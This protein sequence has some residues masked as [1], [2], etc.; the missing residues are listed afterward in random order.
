MPVSR[1]KVQSD[2][3]NRA[4][5][6]RGREQGRRTVWTPGR[7]YLTRRAPSKKEDHWHVRRDAQKR[8]G[9]SRESIYFSFFYIDNVCPLSCQTID[10]KTNL[11]Y[12]RK[13]T[14]IFAQE[15]DL[16]PHYLAFIMKSIESG[17]SL[18]S[19]PIKMYEH[20]FSKGNEDAPL[21]AVGPTAAIST[22]VSR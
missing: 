12:V 2:S 3:G 9:Q 21:V 6:G 10:I 4:K 11:R 1:G 16:D 7:H 18:K 19:D 13:Y 14:V 15:T 8:A 20:L 5:T 22:E 17:M